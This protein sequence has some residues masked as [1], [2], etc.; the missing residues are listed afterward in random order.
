MASRYGGRAAGGD[1]SDYFHREKVADRYRQSAKW[2]RDL[3]HV[4]FGQIACLLS[5]VGVVI[6]TQDI[7][8]LLVVLGYSIS[9]PC[10]WQALRKNNATMINV[11]G[12]CGSMLGIFPMAYTVYCFMWTGGIES[13]RYLRLVQGLI[14]IGVNGMGAFYAK[15]LLALWMNPSRKK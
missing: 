10:C 4:L 12:V 7:P 6:F 13:H 11:Y 15:Q 1:G 5:T 2:K 9:L 3:Q 14:V 8:S